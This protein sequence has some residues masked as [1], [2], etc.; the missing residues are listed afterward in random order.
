MNIRMEVSGRPQLVADQADE[1]RLQPGQACLEVERPRRVDDAHHERDVEEQPAARRT[2]DGSGWR[3]RP[4]GRRPRAWPGAGTPGAAAGNGRSASGDTSR[5]FLAP[6][7][8]PMNFPISPGRTGLHRR[9]L[10]ADPLALAQEV[11]PALGEQLLQRGVGEL[12]PE[13]PLRRPHRHDE[14]RTLRPGEAEE[15]GPLGEERQLAA[16]RG[17]GGDEVG[18]GGLEDVAG[19]PE[20]GPGEGQPRRGDDPDPP[21]RPGHGARVQ[22]LAESGG[23]SVQPVLPDRGQ[24]LLHRGPL[25]EDGHHAQAGEARGGHRHQHHQEGEGTAEAQQFDGNRPRHGQ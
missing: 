6:G 2:P 8:P 1:V 14:H 17:E 5:A 13:H 7:T 11:L 22:G 9:Q 20:P 15:A 23:E 21:V 10:E 24:P 3:R 16:E 4:P 12:G 19:Q 25:V 18:V